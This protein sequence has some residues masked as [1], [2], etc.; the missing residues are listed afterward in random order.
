MSKLNEAREG[1]RLAQIQLDYARMFLR[2]LVERAYEA[3]QR[4]TNE[5]RHRGTE[6]PKPTAAEVTLGLEGLEKAA[7]KFSSD[8]SFLA[9]EERI[10]KLNETRAVGMRP[11]LAAP[12]EGKRY[13]KFDSEP[14]PEN[15]TTQQEMCVA[16]I[17]AVIDRKPPETPAVPTNRHGQTCAQTCGSM[18]APFGTHTIAVPK[19]PTE[20]PADTLVPSAGLAGRAVF[21]PRDGAL[22][23]RDRNGDV[24]A[25]NPGSSLYSTVSM[26]AE[27]VY[28]GGTWR[29]V[30]PDDEYHLA[31]PEDDGEEGATT[32]KT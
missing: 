8:S 15:L 26:M 20:T 30:T 13:H 24:I 21:T 29:R 6:T 31:N 25:A 3:G 32:D 19:S 7:V 10:A 17:A 5:D 11:E 9:V 14:S 28:E 27:E 22:K 23:G 1:V 4:T 18:A 2:D 16:E 12:Y